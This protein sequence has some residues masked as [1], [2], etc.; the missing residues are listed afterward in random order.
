[1]SI[2]YTYTVVAINE[3]GRCMEV[4][5]TSPGRVPVLMGARLPFAG[6]SLEAVIAE[7]AP[8][9]YWADLDRPIE[10]PNIGA[11]GAGEASLLADKPQDG[12]QVGE[13]I[14]KMTAM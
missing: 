2:E 8:V 1:M 3:A 13:F 9:R 12:L 6:E 7:F 11:T 10:M 14:T 5:Y 4:E